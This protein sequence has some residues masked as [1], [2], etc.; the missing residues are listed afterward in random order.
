M[1]LTEVCSG[2]LSFSLCFKDL[3]MSKTIGIAKEQGRSYY[4]QTMG[5]K[6]VPCRRFNSSG[7]G[8]LIK[9]GGKRFAGFVAAPLLR[10]NL[11]FATFD[12]DHGGEEEVADCGRKR[13]GSL[14]SCHIGVNVAYTSRESWLLRN[15]QEYAETEACVIVKRVNFN[16]LGICWLRF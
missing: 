5:M 12:K 3:T 6:D 1:S 7:K 15:V 13:I 8:L 10:D 9:R 16:R 2:T 11:Y 4:Q 14:F